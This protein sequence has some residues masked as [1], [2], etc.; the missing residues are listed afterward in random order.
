MT[1]ERSNS[2]RTHT[3]RR[4]FPTLSGRDLLVVGLE[5]T[6]VGVR[7]ASIQLRRASRL[8]RVV[9]RHRRSPF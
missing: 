7:Q 3:T 4:A 1:T 9:S 6:R 5:W 8:G 2:T